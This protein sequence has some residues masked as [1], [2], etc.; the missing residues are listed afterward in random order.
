LIDEPSG[1]TLGSVV[2]YKGAIGTCFGENGFYVAGGMKAFLPMGILAGIY[3]LG[4][5]A[6]YHQLTD[7]L[8]GITNSCINPQVV[9]SCYRTN[10]PFLS[11]FYFAFN[12]EILNNS[13]TQDYI[14]ASGYVRAMALLGGDFYINY[15][16]GSNWNVGADGYVF[17]DFSAG[18]D[19]IT[20]TSISGSITGDGRIGFQFGNPNL[21]YTSIGL[22]FSA[23]IEQEL[24]LTSISKS[25][26]VDCLIKGNTQQ[27]LKF[28]LSS[29]GKKPDCVVEPID[30]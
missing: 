26:S 23:E 29:G 1:I 17:V 9:N 19:A 20:G 4:M 15:I 22:G 21:F 27:G 8:W 30:Q 12:R 13:L 2:V 10:T 16:S 3:N 24:G 6:G 5:M 11:G 28:S 7:E 18:L 25:I 14:L